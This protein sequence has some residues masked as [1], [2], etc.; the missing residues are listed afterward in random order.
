MA[1]LSG[2]EDF[3]RQ[4]APGTPAVQPR[5]IIATPATPI[6]PNLGYDEAWD[7][8]AGWNPWRRR[9]T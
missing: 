6:D 8:A 5:A 1:P 2:L 4:A 7:E 3:I 9:E